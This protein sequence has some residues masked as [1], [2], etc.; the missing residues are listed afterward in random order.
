MMLQAQDPQLSKN[1]IA[2]LIGQAAAA[3][4]FFDMT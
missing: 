2:I 4:F 3:F 1:R